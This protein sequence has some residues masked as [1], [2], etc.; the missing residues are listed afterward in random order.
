MRLTDLEPQF[1]RYEPADASGSEHYQH[2]DAIAEAD[3]VMFE[4]PTCFLARGG[5]SGT[6]SIICWRPR[7]P[8][9]VDPKPGRWEFLG[10]CYDDLTL[11]AG[12]SSVALT[13]GCRAH[14]FVR[15]GEVIPC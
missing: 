4:C 12:S 7:V 13:S 8:P 3:G 11:F 6:H 15:A 9:H 14:F 2:V 10:T 1:L 5:P